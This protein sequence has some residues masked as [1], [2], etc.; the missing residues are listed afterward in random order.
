MRTAVFSPTSSVAPA[1]SIH[2]G[3]LEGMVFV[4]HFCRRPLLRG[5]MLAVADA[6]DDE[7]QRQQ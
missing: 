2:K 6:I 7:L 3:S 5:V 1:S 4:P